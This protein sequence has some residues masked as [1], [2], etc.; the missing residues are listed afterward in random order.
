MKKN[1]IE[2]LEKIL[3]VLLVVTGLAMIVLNL[4]KIING[5]DSQCSLL[6]VLYGLSMSIYGISYLGIARH[7]L[8]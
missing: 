4:I 3:S 6:A 5:G 1:K 8:K 2:R 7:K